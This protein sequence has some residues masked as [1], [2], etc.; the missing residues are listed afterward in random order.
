MLFN[1]FTLG[2]I[3]SGTGA[4]A[5]AID[6]A[7][8]KLQKIVTKSSNQEMLDE[9]EVQ[10]LKSI[11][12][13]GGIYL[14]QEDTEIYPM[15]FSSSS[16]RAVVFSQLVR[17][18]EFSYLEDKYPLIRI[19]SKDYR[20]SDFLD[21]ITSNVAEKLKTPVLIPDAPVDDIEETIDR[22]LSRFT[23]LSLKSYWDD[24]GSALL[25][26][27]PELKTNPVSLPMMGT[28]SE[29]IELGNSLTSIANFSNMLM[30]EI[31]GYRESTQAD[32]LAKRYF[33]FINGFQAFFFEAIDF[34]QASNV[35]LEARFA[36]IV[37]SASED[38]YYQILLDFENDRRVFL[39][40]NAPSFRDGNPLF[41]DDDQKEKLVE[42]VEQAI[43]NDLLG[44]AENVPEEEELTAE[45]KDANMA[46]VSQCALL[47]N[48]KRLKQ[49]NRDN[50]K[51]NI[52][53]SYHNGIPYDGRFIMV[54]NP[55]NNLSAINKMLA[56]KD[57]TSLFELE[58]KEVSELVPKIRLFKVSEDG[59]KE[60]EFVFSQTED[61]ERTR[62]FKK[63][64][65]TFFNSDFDKGS[66]AG[67]KEF[68]FGFNGT[69]PATSRN[70]V[71]CSLTLYF[72][73]FN[74]FIRT[75]KDYNG[76][77]YRFVDLV[78]QPPGDTNKN[79]WLS[80]LEYRPEF[81][82]IRAEVGY[83]IPDDFPP[84]KRDAIMKSNSSL[85]LTMVDHDININNDGTVALTL[86]Y[87]AYIESALKS[88]RYD[89]LATPAITTRR[90]QRAAQYLEI[91]SKDAC[92][93]EELNQIKRS[94][95]AEE[96][97]LRTESLRS[98]FR[99]LMKNKKIH[100]LNINA[101]DKNKFINKGYF[102]DIPRLTNLSNMVI[103]NTQSPSDALDT[104]DDVSKTL[105]SDLLERAPGSDLD[106]FPRTNE[107]NFFYLG[108][109]LYVILDTINSNIPGVQAL[110][111]AKIIL[112]SLD[113]PSYRENGTPLSINIADIPVSVD[114]FYEWFT[115]RVLAQGDTRKT[116]P[117]LTF[118]REL[119]NQLITPALLEN[120][121]NRSIEKKL[122][123]QSSSITI[124]DPNDKLKQEVEGSVANG[125]LAID[126]T[127]SQNIPFY[128]MDYSG[129]NVGDPNTFRPD[130]SQLS[131][132]LFIYP[133]GKPARHEG[134]GK[135]LQDVERG[136]FHIDVGRNKGL[137][138]T[139]NFNK[140]DMQYVREAR[141][142]QQ[143]GIS[144]ILQMAAVY[145]A[146]VEMV[147]NTI[148][149]PG[150]ELYINP[151]GIGGTAFGSPTDPQSIANKLGFGGYHTIVSVTSRITPGSF[152][153]SVVA[154][155]YYSGDG[156]TR[157]AQK[158]TYRTMQ[159]M[160]IAN[161]PAN[162]DKTFCNVA[163]QAAEFDL[164]QLTGD[165][166]A[167]MT[168]I[169]DIESKAAQIQQG[170]AVSVATVDANLNATLGAESDNAEDVIEAVLDAEVGA[171]SDPD[172]DMTAADIDADHDARYG[173]ESDPGSPAPTASPAT[174]APPA[175]PAPPVSQQQQ[176]QQQP[177][178]Q[179]AITSQSI[180]VT[181]RMP[182]G[183]NLMEAKNKLK[184][185][186][187]SNSQAAGGGQKVLANDDVLIYDV[188]KSKS[189]A[190]A[191]VNATAKS[192]EADAPPVRDGGGESYIEIENDWFLVATIL[193]RGSANA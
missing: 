192:I 138:K 107:I 101:L 60:T 22:A 58:N 30:S 111:K 115:D 126:L 179:S 90:I 25:D 152:Q 100:T 96:D 185:I 190:L 155:Q 187:Y 133:V 137:V 3:T 32:Y 106:T 34:E 82:K 130:P 153:T 80:R 183:F 143:N 125:K 40:L 123:F 55:D 15:E 161:A 88:Y 94:Y 117:I 99:R 6:E 147:G 110:S 168:P 98:V 124:Y 70:D 68:T 91:L 136:C 21:R 26:A 162:R 72:Q 160:N 33:E 19:V 65:P 103:Q 50:I 97:V 57:L 14:F 135:Y 151:F 184:E 27:Y 69:N 112:S 51:N 36:A 31:G 186:A 154:Q 37:E 86:S 102:K 18:D 89:A 116:F 128:S 43:L 142:V 12:I 9:A 52:S 78:I 13:A 84:E 8:E 75:R 87:R 20:Y 39:L 45:E 170:S 1:I 149:Y 159:G 118:I 79:D 35:P 93:Q 191:N 2:A 164:A 145:K 121:Y 157:A 49:A 166:S 181:Y 71:E 132:L 76:N 10:F 5:K 178:S 48:L 120:C 28:M 24:K 104:I 66:G 134:T 54:E 188:S 127:N 193:E 167:P 144:D 182:T 176:Q 163:I 150:M 105:T 38:I 171:E 77:D 165:L 74:D 180:P 23:N 41:E 131:T 177:L 174:P 141:F 95:E 175:P 63:P 56:N 73:T 119:C 122:R 16:D 172:A 148:F 129:A 92:T 42:N 173:A 62:N 11:M 113:V 67:V 83:Y 158:G 53:D 114:Y 189:F 7:K 4:R 61:V 59:T 81:Y 169:E 108:D 109:L 140:T 17:Q 29:T 44:I 139:I 64:G 46:L 47:L 156:R 85:S 146:S